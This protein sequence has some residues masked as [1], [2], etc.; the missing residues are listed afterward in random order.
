LISG[1]PPYIECDP[2]SLFAL[3]LSE[4]PI[5]MSVHRDEGVPEELVAL[6]SKCMAKSASERFES[7]EELSARVD[8]LRI[9]YPWT[10]DQAR[11]WWKVHADND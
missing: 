6:V 4:E 2:E 5:S 10:A 7:V 1:R 9:E 3:V 8:E 11:E